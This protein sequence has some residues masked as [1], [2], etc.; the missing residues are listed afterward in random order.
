MVFSSLTFVC[1]FLPVVFC[2]YW[3]IP[4]IKIQNFVLILASLLFYAY[5]EPSFVIFMLIS[6][7]FNYGCALLIGKTEKK[8]KK[9]LLGLNI[10][11]NLSF[12]GYFKY[13]AMV[14][15]TINQIANCK[16]NVPEIILPMGISF[17]T[18]QTMSYVIDV[19]RGI[20]SAE[21]NLAKVLLYISFFPQLI[22][23]P[24]VKYHDIAGFLS[25][26]QKDVKQAAEGFRRFC[27]GLTKK[28][29]IAN[30]M[31]YAVD[32]IFAMSQVNALL[33]WI[34][35]IGYM[36]QIYYDFSGYSDM[37]IGMG[38]M[39]GFSFQENFI[40]PY[41]ADSMKEFW[42]RWHISLSSWFKEYV[43]I[44]LGGNRKGKGK[45]V[46]NKLIVF[47][48]T[49]LWH[50]ANW[51][52]VV[53]GL[54]HG[55]FLMLEEYI[56]LPVA[57]L[58]RPVKHIYACLVVCIGF[59]VFRAEHLLQAGYMIKSMATGFYNTPELT[60]G[61]HRI[62]TD[63]FLIMLVL[64][65]IF[66]TPIVKWIKKLLEKAGNT[67]LQA[68]R[69]VSFIG[70]LWMLFMCLLNLAGNSYNPFIYFRF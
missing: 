26:R 49:G 8:T 16:W 46:R 36:L 63:Q 68:G 70:A 21:K 23:G 33:A 60:D 69:I 14:I 53:W 58:L 20:Y 12:L 2:L 52:F 10:I 32:E 5:G 31:G 56:S 44:P 55:F 38:M 42:R 39:F 24:I 66:A 11:S 9:W 47:F 62:L 1:V 7:F 51:T 41:S 3:I 29:M 17:F 15:N 40:N 48:C 61:L 67:W 35:A 57:K 22:A 43:Y 45:T 30:V 13:T 6:V 37:A 50:G 59:V 18:F 25:N 65:V 27:Y 54:Y 34:G 64:G 4:N 19:Y 28:V